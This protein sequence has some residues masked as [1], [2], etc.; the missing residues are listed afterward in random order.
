MLFNVCAVALGGA[1]GATARY[2]VGVA[3]S[4]WG[5]HASALSGFPLAT[6]L[7]NATGCFL[8]GVLSVVFAS[9]GMQGKELW[10][11]FAITGI[12]GGFTTFSTFSL[13]TL[14]LFQDGAIG[15]AGVNVVASLVT[16]LAGVLAGRALASAV[17]GIRA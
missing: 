2:L 16:C 1:F 11:L 8:I 12:M 14:T 7:A 10:R 3:V 17:L 4:T 13:E 6:F 9:E 5:P 15:M